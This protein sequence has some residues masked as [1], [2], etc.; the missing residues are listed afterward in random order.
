MPEGEKLS[1]IFV[2]I[3]Q[4]RG[5]GYVHSYNDKKNIFENQWFSVEKQYF[6]A[7]L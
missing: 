1:G 3:L 6:T 2:Y 7:L 4:I 5:S